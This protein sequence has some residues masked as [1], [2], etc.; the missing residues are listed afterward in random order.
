[1]ISALR[2]S[3]IRVTVLQPEVTGCRIWRHFFRNIDH[4][5]FFLIGAPFAFDGLL[6]GVLVA[7]CSAMQFG[8]DFNVC[9]FLGVVM[10]GQFICLSIGR[11]LRSPEARARFIG[12]LINY[13]SKGSFA[14]LPRPLRSIRWL[15]INPLVRHLCDHAIDG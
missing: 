12:N 10:I 8:S 9:D 5:H 1:M 7:N 3:F 2:L 11:F 4:N 14:G 13:L 6:L 15:N